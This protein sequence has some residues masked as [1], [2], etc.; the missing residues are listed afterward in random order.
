MSE[1]GKAAEAPPNNASTNTEIEVR[2]VK[3]TGPMNH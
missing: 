2:V 3:P 1:P